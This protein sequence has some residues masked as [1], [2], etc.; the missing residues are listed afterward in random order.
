MN[1]TVIQHSFQFNR[2]IHRMHTNEC[3]DYD[4]KLFCNQK[5]I[6]D[7]WGISFICEVFAR[8]KIMEY[9]SFFPIPQFNKHS[10]SFTPVC[11]SLRLFVTFCKSLKVSVVFGR[12]C[13]CLYSVGEGSS[14]NH[15]TIHLNR[16]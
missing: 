1:V 4:V 16:K 11:C 14:L 15:S 2:K 10:L 5:L 12:A 7:V 6:Q 3:Y 9:D 8:K 13:Q